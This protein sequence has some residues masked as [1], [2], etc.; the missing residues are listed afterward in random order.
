MDNKIS[1][2]KLA[3]SIL[4]ALCREDGVSFV[5]VSVDFESTEDGV[6]FVGKTL[7][8]G[9]TIYKIVNNYIDNS[10]KI[11]GKK[12]LQ[13]AKQKENFLISLANNLRNIVYNENSFSDYLEELTLSSLYQKPVVWILMKNLICPI[14]NV[15]LKNIKIVIGTTPYIDITR[16]YER[17]E[18]KKDDNISYPFIFVNEVDC[19]VT[20]NAFLF[21]D[22]LKA[23]GLSPIEVIKDIFESELYDKLKGILKLSF[24]TEGRINKFISTLISI[25]G[26]NLLDFVPIRKIAQRANPGINPDMASQW[27]YLG[28]LERMLEPARG[29]DWST[30]ETLEKYHED[31]WNKVE[32]LKNKRAKKGMDRGVPFDV[33]LRLKST[34]T[35]DNKTDPTQILQSLLSSERIW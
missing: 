2:F 1:D 35:V 22:T 21:I 24:D 33:L 17:G 3:E 32:D 5:D 27:W 26:V 12:L 8:I 28:V 7:N 31:F 30:Y 13:N 14:Y 23:Y 6:L 25:L 15:P 4:K 16:Y 11:V 10:E 9:H 34:Q 29:A 19:T 18:I 20:Q